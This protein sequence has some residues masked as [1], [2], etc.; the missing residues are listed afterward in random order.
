M[1][2]EDMD[3][4]EVNVSVK[5]TATSDYEAY[6]IVDYV[7]GQANE[8]AAG[9]WHDYPVENWFHIYADKV[10]DGKK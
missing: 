6:D 3:L 10:R 9:L 1:T 2:N 4:Y 8:V 7:L 5:V